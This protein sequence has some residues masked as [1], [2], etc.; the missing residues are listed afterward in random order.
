MS[1]EVLAD[2]HGVLPTG[3]PRV[4]GKMCCLYKYQREWMA[5][6]VIAS[7]CTDIDQRMSKIFKDRQRPSWGFILTPCQKEIKL[8]E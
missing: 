8:P 2:L 5:R 4:K 6:P 3:N 7:V 1:F